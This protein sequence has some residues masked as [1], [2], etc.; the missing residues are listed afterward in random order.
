MRTDNRSCEGVGTLRIHKV[1]QSVYGEMVQKLGAFRTLTGGN[2]AKAN[3]K[4]TALHVE[5]AQARGS[6]WAD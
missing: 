5:L 1:E 3:P 6:R 2:P 4:I